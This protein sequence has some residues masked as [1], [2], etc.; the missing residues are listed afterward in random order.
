[1]MAFHLSENV[2][3]YPEQKSGFSFFFSIKMG[4]HKI[5]EKWRKGLVTAKQFVA[6]TETRGLSIF[7]K[8]MWKKIFFDYTRDAQ[9]YMAFSVSFIA[10]NLKVFSLNTCS[11]CNLSLLKNYH[12]AI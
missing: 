3:N 11:F 6:Q 9:K 4:K 7:C 12:E 2:L 8:D 5:S 10:T 1:M